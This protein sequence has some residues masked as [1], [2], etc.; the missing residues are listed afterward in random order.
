M[1]AAR[2]LPT[3]VKHWPRRLLQRWLVLALAAPLALAAWAQTEAP[4]AM[5]RR[6]S[7]EVLN[8]LQTSRTGPGS[9]EVMAKVQ[10][11]V[12]PNFDFERITA[13]ATGVS[14][15]GATPAQ[16]AQLTEQFRTL[17]VRTY[18]SSLSRYQN[19]TLEVQAPRYSGDKKKANLR[20]LLRQ[21]GAPT[22]TIDYRMAADAASWKVYDVSVD[23]VSLVT[24]YRDTFADE[25]RNNGVDGLIRMLIDKNQTLAS[26]AAA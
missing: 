20:S 7:D 2:T 6:V 21:P 12:L 3:V 1:S 5:V 4:D 16:R 13:L 25:V 14:W 18:S 15:R 26:K 22:I 9:P 10:A 23:G 8:I 24:T 19:Q 11:L 17:L